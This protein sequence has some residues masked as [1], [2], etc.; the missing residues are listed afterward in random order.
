MF[1]LRS[2]IL[3]EVVV[4]FPSDRG[5]CSCQYF[6]IQIYPGVFVSAVVSSVQDASNSGERLAIEAV[7]WSTVTLAL[8]LCVRVQQVSLLVCAPQHSHGSAPKHSELITHKRHGTIRLDCRSSPRWTDTLSFRF[9]W[10]QAGQLGRDKLEMFTHWH[11]CFAETRRHLV[12]F[13][14]A[15]GQGYWLCCLREICGRGCVYSSESTLLIF[16]LVYIMKV[17]SHKHDC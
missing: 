2:S 7:T 15:L 3:V 17:D 10:H 8:G 16:G 4:S 14:L 11:F 13:S 5:F 1:V 12:E 6:F 9:C